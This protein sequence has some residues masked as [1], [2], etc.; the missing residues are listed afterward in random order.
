MCISLNNV[1][2]IFS[3]KNNCKK[4]NLL[5]GKNGLFPEIVDFYSW[6]LLTLSLFGLLTKITSLQWTLL[7]VYLCLQ[8]VTSLFFFSATNLGFFGKTNL[9]P[10]LY[11]PLIFLKYTGRNKNSHFNVLT[12]LGMYLFSI[13]TFFQEGISV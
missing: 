5:F 3:K 8:N 10:F 6:V 1:Y 13:I 12:D 7:Q 4:K 2:F 11:F 9:I